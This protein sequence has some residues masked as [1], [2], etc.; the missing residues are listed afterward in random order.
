MGRVTVSVLLVV[1]VVST[2]VPVL[3]CDAWNASTSYRGNIRHHDFNDFAFLFRSASQ[4]YCGQVTAERLSAKLSSVP[5]SVWTEW[6][7]GGALSFVIATG[8]QLGPQGHLSA[9]L[10]GQ[11]RDAANAYSFSLQPGGCS[12]ASGNTC[13]EDYAM[14]VAAHGW[15]T[16]YYRLSGRAWTSPRSSTLSAFRNTLSFSTT[17]FRK[18]VN[19]SP[20]V[21]CDATITG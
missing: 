21:L 9:T 13:L 15:R 18:T 10:D 17:C 8:L 7:A 20:T 19:P 5:S 16:A 2:A 1:L 6:L 11:I 12:Y 3:A 4:P 14:N